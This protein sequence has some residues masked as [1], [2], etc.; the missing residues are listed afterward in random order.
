MS[1]SHYSAQ[2]P[3]K[4][5]MRNDTGRWVLEPQNEGLGFRV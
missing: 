5:I 3:I 1:L 4:H 2:N